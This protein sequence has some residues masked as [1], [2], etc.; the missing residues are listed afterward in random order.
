MIGKL[1]FFLFPLLMALAASSD[2]LTM[3]ISNRLVIVLVAGF[4]ALALAIHLPLQEFA[5]HLTCALIVLVVAFGLFSMR[6]IGGGDAK[7]AAATTLWLGFG[8]TLP[9][10]VYSALFGGVLTLVLLTVR[11]LPL[12]QFLT[13]IGWIQRLH[14]RKSGVPYGIALAV[15]G[16]VTYFDTALYQQLIG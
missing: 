8:E 12:P 7:L 3:R 2:L 15:A 4:L 14:N 16:L 10:L 13:R 11:R 6:W 5:M 9:Y 1:A